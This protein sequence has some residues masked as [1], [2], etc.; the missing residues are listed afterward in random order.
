MG[1]ARKAQSG[2]G[3]SFPR[4]NIRCGVETECGSVCVD[5]AQRNERPKNEVESL[6][7]KFENEATMAVRSGYGIYRIYACVA[8]L[9]AGLSS[10][11]IGVS[12]SS[13]GEIM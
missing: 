9:V 8:G 2:L 12:E 10:K 1:I 11:K 7:A 5:M 4:L 3:P 13:V 6:S